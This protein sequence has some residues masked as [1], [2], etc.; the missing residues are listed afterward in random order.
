[1]FKTCTIPMGVCIMPFEEKPVCCAAF[2]LVAPPR[3][4]WAREHE[5]FAMVE[6]Y[7]HCHFRTME[8]MPL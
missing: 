6:P 1:M 4:V 5:V 8:D 2:L 3:R 7:Q